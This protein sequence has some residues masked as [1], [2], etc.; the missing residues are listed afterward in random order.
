M[1]TY[2]AGY[3]SSDPF[4]L[5]SS[6]EVEEIPDRI[7]HHNRTK[8]RGER[9]QEQREEYWTW[10]ELGRIRRKRTLG[11]ARRISPPQRTVGGESGEALG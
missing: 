9:Q 3:W 6:D 1:D 10:D 11:S 8:R 4:C 2:H 5:S 7:T